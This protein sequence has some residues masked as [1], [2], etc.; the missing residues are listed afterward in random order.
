MQQSLGKDHQLNLTYL[1]HICHTTL[2]YCSSVNFAFQC[3]RSAIRLMPKTFQLRGT[4]VS[5][6]TGILCIVCIIDTKQRKCDQYQ[7]A[8]DRGIGKLS[9]TM[10][11]I[12]YLEGRMGKIKGTGQPGAETAITHSRYDKLIHLLMKNQRLPHA[13]LIYN[14]V[15]QPK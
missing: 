7:I 9:N 10:T 12:Q 15:N 1:L 6:R 5:G 2:F 11:W 13:A 4:Q 14:P 8:S 3:S